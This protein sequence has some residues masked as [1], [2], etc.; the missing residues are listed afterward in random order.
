[1]LQAFARER[2][3][4]GGGADQE[5]ARPRVGRRPDEVADP[6]EAGWRPTDA[7]EQLLR[8]HAGVT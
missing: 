6:L 3:A 5:P 4:A 7:I 1:M 8:V 2:G